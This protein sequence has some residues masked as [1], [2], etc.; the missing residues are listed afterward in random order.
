MHRKKFAKGKRYNC[1]R[2]RM[3]LKNLFILERFFFSP[4]EFGN[5]SMCANGIKQNDS[6]KAVRVVCIFSCLFLTNI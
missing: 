4:I 3:R 2:N 1:D 6:E 5:Y